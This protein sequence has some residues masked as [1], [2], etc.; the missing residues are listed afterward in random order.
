MYDVGHHVN[1]LDANMI[2]INLLW[3][4]IFKRIRHFDSF[5]GPRS[6]TGRLWPDPDTVSRIEFAANRACSYVTLARY[7]PISSSRRSRNAHVM[8]AVKVQ[9]W[10]PRVNLTFSFLSRFSRHLIYFIPN[11]Q[12]AVR[13]VVTAVFRLVDNISSSSLQI[14]HWPNYKLDSLVNSTRDNDFEDTSIWVNSQATNT[15]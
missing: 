3:S 8:I 9:S 4:N 7:R 15:W 12:P 10:P 5:Y 11:R 2:V 14:V 13:I 6:R 1:L